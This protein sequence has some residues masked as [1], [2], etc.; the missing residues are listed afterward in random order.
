MMNFNLTELTLCKKLL[1]RLRVRCPLN[2]YHLITS[3]MDPNTAAYLVNTTIHACLINTTTI[4][5]SLVNKTINL[6]HRHTVQVQTERE[7]MMKVMKAYKLFT[8][9][10]DHHSS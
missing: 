9:R 4:H 8:K 5:A 7:M 2:R 10:R 6:S 3:L 1:I